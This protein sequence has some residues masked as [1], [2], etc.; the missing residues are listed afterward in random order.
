MKLVYIAGP[1]RGENTSEVTH[2]IQRAREAAEEVW[3]A[4]GA[5]LCPHLNSAYMDGLVDDEAFLEAGLLMLERCDAVRV[6]S[7][8]HPGG[9]RS[10]G[11]EREFVRAR[12]LGMPVLYSLSDVVGF[13]GDGEARS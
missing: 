2:N 10:E 12:Q 7:I 13:L 4:G 3:L 5:A 11:T 9:R 8:S 6:I 1:Y